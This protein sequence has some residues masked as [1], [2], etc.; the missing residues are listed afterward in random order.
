MGVLSDQLT[1]LIE[2]MKEANERE[3]QATRDFLASMSTHLDEMGKHID[4]LAED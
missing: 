1:S 4:E 2:Q 3:A